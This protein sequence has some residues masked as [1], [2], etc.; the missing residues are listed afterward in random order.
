MPELE[1]NGTQ[2]YYEDT[3][4][5]KP[6]IL[7]AHGLLFSSQ[8]FEFQIER[9]AEHYRCISFDFRGQ[10]LS[11]SPATGYEMANLVSDTRDLIE[12]LQIAPVHFVGLSMG[13]YVGLKLASDHSHLIRSLTLI[14][15]S[16]EAISKEE[17][18]RLRR[19]SLVGRWLGY[20]MITGKIM[21]KIFGPAFRED[22]KLYQEQLIWRNRLLSNNRKGITRAVNGALKR[23]DI[24]QSL[25]QISKPTLILVGEDDEVT[26]I[27]QAE[28]MQN[29]ISN[30]T[31]HIIPQAGHMLSAE[32]PDEVCDY[33]MEHLKKVDGSS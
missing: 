22:P 26:P 3:G 31:M 1:I 24:S 6:V 30:A 10:G 27:D 33:I 18:Q 25:Y 2:I 11:E 20:T 23:E 15:T 7:F 16:P 17:Y 14:S 9:L 32:A 19:L 8:M 21:R 12:Q 5:D 13:G 29:R 4:G 28:K